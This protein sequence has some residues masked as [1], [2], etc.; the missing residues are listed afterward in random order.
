MDDFIQ[1]FAIPA[2]EGG[3]VKEINLRGVRDGILEL[4]TVEGGPV[5]L[6][7]GDRKLGGAQTSLAAG[8]EQPDFLVA[9]AVGQKAEVKVSTKLA[10]MTLFA[11]AGSFGFVRVRDCKS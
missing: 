6:F 2:A 8:V 1:P 4:H 11:K 7:N 9:A 3:A 10:Q 5:Y